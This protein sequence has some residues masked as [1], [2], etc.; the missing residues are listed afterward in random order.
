VYRTDI[1]TFV[2]SVDQLS[3]PTVVQFSTYN[4]NGNNSRSGVLDM[5]KQILVPAGF[6]DSPFTIYANDHPHAMMSNLFWRHCDLSPD[7]ATVENLWI[8]LQAAQ[9]RFKSPE[10]V[11]THSPRSAE[12]R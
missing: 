5:M 1:K 11:D 9:G 6:T 10:A 3:M 8:D 7:K 2:K 4:T 12:S